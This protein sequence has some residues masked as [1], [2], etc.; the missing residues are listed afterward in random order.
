MCRVSQSILLL[1]P[2]HPEVAHTPPGLNRAL[3][4]QNLVLLVDDLAFQARP[5]FHTKELSAL[6][7]ALM[8][9]L[10]LAR[11]TFSLA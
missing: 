1:P 5:L 10:R 2:G 9:S 3:S 6:L 7:R 11:H 8:A 4:C